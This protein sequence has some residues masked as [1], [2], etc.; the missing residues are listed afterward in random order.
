MRRRSLT[1]A[2]TLLEIMVS[3]GVM[4]MI[5]LLI[6]GA[7]DSLS[8]GRKGEQL[9]SDRARQGRDAMERITH[10]LQTAFLSLHTP[11]QPALSAWSPGAS[12]APIS[13]GP[14]GRRQEGCLLL[15]GR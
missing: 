10:E 11:A 4:A 3:L 1:R 15:P 5:S 6:Y 12:C 7:F 2:M 9:R 13:L 14:A 8:R